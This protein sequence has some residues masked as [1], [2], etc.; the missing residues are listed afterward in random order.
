MTKPSPPL[1]AVDDSRP[2]IRSFHL[3]YEVAEEDHEA[4]AKIL[5]EIDT[6]VAALRTS[7]FLRQVAG[8]FPDGVEAIELHATDENDDGFQVL[9]F[10][11]DGWSAGPD[12]KLSPVRIPDEWVEEIREY[13]F[14]GDAN[15]EGKIIEIMGPDAKS[16]GPLGPDGFFAWAK[17]VWGEAARARMEA[18][19]L[20]RALPPAS[21]TPRP[22]RM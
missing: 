8:M 1:A 7:M 2:G 14:W 18:F 9:E 16:R 11:A 17:E 4:T 20:E 10:Q 22:S 5:D 19:D 13:S 21:P 12:G 6:H 3:P 15:F